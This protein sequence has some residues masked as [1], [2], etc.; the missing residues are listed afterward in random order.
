MG[1][2]ATEAIH[3]GHLDEDDSIQSIGGKSYP[4]HARLVMHSTTKDD[5]HLGRPPEYPAV[6]VASLSIDL[7]QVSVILERHERRL[8]PLCLLKLVVINI[9]GRIVIEAPMILFS[10]T[11]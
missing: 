11:T 2:G 5:E 6:N 10:A 7:G 9:A 1:S 3:P 4:R 8:S